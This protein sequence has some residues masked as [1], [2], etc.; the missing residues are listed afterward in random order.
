MKYLFLICMAFS[1]LSCN[2]THNESQTITQPKTPSILKAQ[3]LPV[4]DGKGDDVCWQKSD[5]KTLDQVWLGDAPSKTD[6]EGRYK[7]AW[8]EDYIYVLAE[9]QDDTLIDI[10]ADGLDRY[11]DDDCLE[12]FIDEDASGGNHQYSHNAFAYHISLDG[13][14]VDIGPD[15]LF[16]YYPEHCTSKRITQ[17]STSM[18]EV[19][20][21][22]YD[23]TYQDGSTT[24]QPVKLKANKQVGFALAYCDNDHSAE[25]ENFIGSIFVEGEDKNR[26]WIDAGIFEKLTLQDA[27]PK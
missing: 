14:N 13:Q 10:H 15:S 22:I 27:L 25:R 19:A 16:R 17:G 26:G 23:D 3:I 20:M 7:L 24:N 8:S 12:L 6:F 18:W 1:V 4:I 9:I 11:W 5:W 21:A 2:S